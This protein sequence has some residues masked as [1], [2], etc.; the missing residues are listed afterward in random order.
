MAFHG[1]SYG[2]DAELLS[3]RSAQYDADF[4]NEVVSWV[5]A[6]SG[7]PSEGC[8]SAHAY[9]KNGVALC[10]AVNA[11]KPGMCRY[12]TSRMPFRVMENINSFL[13]ACRALGMRTTDLFQTVDLYEAKNMICVLQCIAA[14][15]RILGN[16]MPSTLPRTVSIIDDLDAAPAEPLCGAVQ[17]QEPEPEPESDLPERPEE[18]PSQ[19]PAVRFCMECGTKATGGRFCTECGAKLFY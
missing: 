18:A 16:G 8:E 6:M 7:E 4:E 19:P 3:K 13:E 11:A 14:L 12:T 2:L 17:A 5:E 15:H 10:K 9:L 1:P